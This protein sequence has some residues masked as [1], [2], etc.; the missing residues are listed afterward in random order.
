MHYA[1][2]GVLTAAQL[3]DQNLSAQAETV[4]NQL[5]KSGLLLVQSGPNAGKHAVW[6]TT[7]YANCVAAQK[8]KLR[9]SAANILAPGGTPNWVLFAGVGAVVLIGGALWLKRRS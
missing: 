3:A 8:A 9:Y 7:E 6:G 5:S 1:A 4:C 2:L